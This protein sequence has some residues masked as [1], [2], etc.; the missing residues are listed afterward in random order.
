MVRLPS[1]T[2][3]KCG[4]PGSA[5]QDAVYDRVGNILLSRIMGAETQL[6]D[7]CFDIG[8]RESWTKALE[9][10]KA[11]GA[12]PTPFRPAHLS[13]NWVASVT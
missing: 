6:V 10:V 3:P 1:E 4:R 12:N 11:K 2:L 13:I 5:A 8:I 9:D 7:E